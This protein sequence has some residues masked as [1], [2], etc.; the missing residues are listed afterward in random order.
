MARRINR[1]LVLEGYLVADTPVHVGS[2]D[3]GHQV[4]MP[5]A[6][7]GMGRFYIPGTSLAGAIRAWEMSE[8]KHEWWGR[9]EGIA[10]MVVVDDAPVET[11]TN[12]ELWHGNGI[13]RFSGGAFE[14]IKFDRQVLPKGTRFRFRLQREISKGEDISET[15]RWMGHLLAALESGEISFGG[16]VSRG[17]GRLS[18][19]N[20]TGSE[21]DWSSRSGILSWLDYGPSPSI[22]GWRKEFSAV[23]KSASRTLSIE[24][25]WQPLGP[26]MSKS[27]SE[28]M[29]VDSMPFVSADGKS[30]A[31]TLPGSSIKGA[32]RQQAERIVRTVLENAG[33]IEAQQHFEQIDLP[34]VRELFGSSRQGK[35]GEQG[36]RSRLYVDTCY[37]ELSLARREWNDLDKDVESWKKTRYPLV[38]ADHVSI[39][40]WT[41]A[42]LEGALFNTA[43]PDKSVKW[44]P[45]RLKF[46]CGRG[47]DQAPL[48]L[49]WLVLR[50]FCSGKIP[51]GFGV[52]RGYG[53]LAVKS[54]SF[55][56]LFS[57]GYDKDSMEIEIENGTPRTQ[58]HAD[59]IET[60]KKHW[61][62]WLETQRSKEVA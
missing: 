58:A 44:E 14:G 26:L 62:A 56:G 11:K 1:T 37:S 5:F 17:F 48:S 4:D 57:F 61:T 55:S 13:D 3:T 21:I 29:A 16:S 41:G 30:Y 6:A 9:L 27:A 19:K 23:S 52:N 59:F 25:N 22:E 7:D 51:L 40:R 10:S 20:A 32:L 49:L 2:A 50:D 15:R 39:D 8:K 31:M 12:A 34:L 45:I 36:A 24:I 35:D 33:H 54:I 38:K 47:G 43:E 46:D 18:L 60:L 53:D 42:G 28:G